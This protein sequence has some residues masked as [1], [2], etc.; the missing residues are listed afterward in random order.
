MPEINVTRFFRTA[1]P[2]DYS[3]SVAELGTNAGRITWGNAT[4][5]AAESPLL[6]T[7]EEIEAMRD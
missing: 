1:E 2:S 3:A 4:R 7:E 6:T 5:E